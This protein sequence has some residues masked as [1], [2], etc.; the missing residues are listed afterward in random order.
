VGAFIVKF[1]IFG[2]HYWLPVAHVEASTIGSMLLAGI[3]LKIGCIGVFYVVY[4]LNCII[5]LH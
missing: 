2:F 5:K 4:Y 1:P 3:L